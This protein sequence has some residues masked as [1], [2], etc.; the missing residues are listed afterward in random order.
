MEWKVLILICINWFW[1]RL[2]AKSFSFLLINVIFNDLNFCFGSIKWF[3][4]QLVAQIIIFP[5]HDD[6]RG[7]N[8]GWC[9]MSTCWMSMTQFKSKQIYQIYFNLFK[10]F[11]G[12][13][14]DECEAEWRVRSP[15]SPHTDVT[16]SF[17][18]EHSSK[19]LIGCSG[20]RRP[21]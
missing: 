15:P 6:K 18:I 14:Q 12:Y 17:R 7:F 10:L 5:I 13:L 21:C 9:F 8:L 19:H 2:V 1:S 3:W 11:T 16:S 20:K 4:S